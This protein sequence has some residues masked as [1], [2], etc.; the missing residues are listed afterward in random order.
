MVVLVYVLCFAAMAWSGM[1]VDG[2]LNGGEIPFF[3]KEET[4][5]P[6]GNPTKD[7]L[8]LPP[9]PDKQSIGCDTALVLLP[10]CMMNPEQY[11]SF[12]HK[13][14]QHTSDS[15]L[16]IY[17]S[18]KAHGFSNP[19]VVGGCVRSALEELKRSGFPGNAVFVGGHSLGAAFL[20]S[21]WSE[22]GHEQVNGFVHLGCVVPRNERMSEQ[23]ATKPRLT[24]CGDLDGLV[25]TSRV[26]EDYYRNV[27][28]VGNTQADKLHHAVVVVRGMNHVGIVEGKTTFMH[29]WRDLQAEITKEESM[30]EVASVVAQFISYHDNGNQNAAHAL[31]GKIEHTFEYLQPLIE[32]MKLEGSYHLEKP[33]YLCDLD[34]EEPCRGGSAWTARAQDTLI[35]VGTGCTK[36]MGPHDS[37]N[38][39]SQVTH[40][41]LFQSWWFNPFPDPPLHLPLIT[42]VQKGNIN[43]KTVSELVYE[44]PDASLFDA[45]FFSNTAL[46]IRAK[47]N[48]QQSILHAQGYED[49]TFAQNSKS[50][51][52]IN[53]RTL[54]WAM[55]QAHAVA[56]QRYQERGVRLVAGT[57]IERRAGTL[58]LSSMY[59]SF[60]TLTILLTGFAWI[61]TYLK[62][63]RTDSKSSKFCYIVQLF[64]LTKAYT[65]QQLFWSHH[66]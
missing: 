16:W 47:M 27:E 60:F 9:L 11:A 48:S 19:F 8:L 17:V 62:Y 24:V 14:Q 5:S 44:T 37:E 7:G 52:R 49:A 33:C 20:S 54:E 29:E 41:E 18:N 35:P 25:R 36:E 40:D 58:H 66:L 4:S 23:Y 32:A 26:A 45:G 56:R 21:V 57:D 46:E 34:E 64:P 12:A 43:M 53:E 10:G 38:G 51:S 1:P 6:V 2:F 30:R 22:L 28:S 3:P 59:E 42:E 31:R 13:L 61:W 65:Y 55:E 39:G 15:A 50:C 63:R